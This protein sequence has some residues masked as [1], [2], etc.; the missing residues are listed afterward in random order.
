M[1]NPVYFLDLLLP[2]IEKNFKNYTG[3]SDDYKT[4]FITSPSNV[5]K[6]FKN[7]GRVYKGFK[8]FTTND[9][10]K[11]M[12]RYKEKC[13]LV[14]TLFGDI[15]SLNILMLGSFDAWIF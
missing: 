5:A 7:I 4:I 9:S 1:K 8:I 6:E 15:L 2:H 11:F 13:E 3:D 14:K 12:E 10:E